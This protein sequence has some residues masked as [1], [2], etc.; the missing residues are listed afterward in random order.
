MLDDPYAAARQPADPVGSRSPVQDLSSSSLGVAST[1]CTSRRASRS[2][3][4]AQR[5]T[6]A[7]ARWHP[8]NAATTVLPVVSARKTV[9]LH[10]PLLVVSST[11]FELLFLRNAVNPTDEGWPLYAAMLLH[12]GGRL[13]DDIFF[14][15][16]PGHA[17]S[18]W[19]GLAIDPHGVIATRAI[20]AIFNVALCV[21]IYFLG[22]R[23]MSP[24]Y[25]FLGALLL[26]F[27]APDSHNWQ[28]LFGYRYLVWSVLALLA[29]ARRIETGD[30]RW[31]AL[32]GLFTGIGIAFRIDA[33]AVAWGIGIATVASVRP[34]EWLRD[35][36]WFAAGV[37]LVLAPLLTW[38]A[39]SVGL[40]TLWREVV[41]RPLVMTRLQNVPVPVLLWPASAS[42]YDLHESFE[43]LLFRLPWLLY[44][45]YGVGL[46]ALLVRTRQRGTP[47]RSSLLLA[48]VAWGAAFFTRSLG[49]SDVAHLDSAI[50]PFCLLIAHA[51][52]RILGTHRGGARDGP[53]SAMRWAAIAVV[54]GGWIFL[55]RADVPLLS[56]RRALGGATALLGG[57]K[58]RSG[59]LAETMP[60][61]RA[62]TGP[63]DTILDLN[64][65][66]IVH[67][68]TGR[69]GPGHADVLMPGTLLD[70]S[71]EDAFLQRLEARPPAVVL[72]ARKQFDDLP[73]RAVERTAPR[74]MQWLSEHYAPI[75]KL[76]QGESELWV[77]RARESAAR[78][79]ASDASEAERKAE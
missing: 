59:D 70:A 26:A 56:P 79:S 20:Y 67:L 1:R 48:I 19:V 11:Y 57:A 68:F 39:A 58:I 32:A 76:H 38:F 23:I 10:L 74:V 18:A 14:V 63:S 12:R 6:R 24:G 34:R 72:P 27:A 29:F 77:P 21:T 17:L 35:G 75:E 40:D 50:P 49:R 78:D 42:R 4:G 60:R 15:F 41:V 51:M 28:L 47:F 13:Y 31:L 73:E 64:A 37:F 7:R 61:I 2:P 8:P 66:P 65:T 62:L 3:C 9:W 45:A 25:A 43:Q 33:A 5:T 54:L 46:I 71:E 44:A 22:R 53:R 52:S 69:I 30:V 16:P 55:L 36:A